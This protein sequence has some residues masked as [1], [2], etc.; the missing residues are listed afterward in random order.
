MQCEGYGAIVVA[1]VGV[2]VGVEG[3]VVGGGGGRG[4][5]E[6]DAVV[7]SQRGD[8][9]G[10]GGGGGG[11]GSGGGW[12]HILAT[13][14]AVVDVVE[15]ARVSRRGS[16]AVGGRE[17]G[18]GHDRTAGEHRLALWSTR[19]TLLHRRGPGATEGYVANTQTHIHA[20]THHNV[21]D[22]SLVTFVVTFFILLP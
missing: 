19:L 10:G 4:G 12:G 11:G 5:G 1:V 18:E 15:G 17:G 16:T 13:V 6:G 20:Y 21:H 9:A 7:V 14:E 2:V 8:E 3:V 22:I